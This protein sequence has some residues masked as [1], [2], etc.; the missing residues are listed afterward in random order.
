MKYPNTSEIGNTGIS[1]TP[2]I[3]DRESYSTLM[4]PNAKNVDNHPLMCPYDIEKDVKAF[5]LPELTP[6]PEPQSFPAVSVVAASATSVVLI[7]IGLLVILQEAQKVSSAGSFPFFPEVTSYGCLE[8][9]W[10]FAVDD[11]AYCVWGDYAF[12]ADYAVY[13]VSSGNVKRGVPNHQFFWRVLPHFVWAALFDFLVFAADGGG[14]KLQQFRDNI[15]RLPR[16]M[17]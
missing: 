17:R 3:I 4:F 14:V 9:P 1:N 16:L 8:N 12:F 5:L 15:E 10:V 7:T 13:E 2:Y 11:F 6:T